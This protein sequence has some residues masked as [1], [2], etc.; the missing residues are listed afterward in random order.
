VPTVKGIFDVASVPTGS[1][2]IDVTVTGHQFWWQFEYPQQHITTANELHMP[3]GTPVYLSL[4]GADVIH[5]FW[6]PELSGT[7][8][9]VP[10]H[11]NH[12]MLQTNRPGIYLGQCKEFCG[13]SHANM[14]IRVFVQRPA[15]YQSWVAAQQQPAEAASLSGAAAAGQKLFLHGSSGGAFPGGPACSGC[16]SVSGTSAQGVIGP[17][18]THFGTRTRFASETYVNNTANLTNW[19]ENPPAL[20]PGVD[21][22]RLG[23]SSTQIRDL[24]AYLQSLK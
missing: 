2:V 5:S 22:P 19:L 1:N 13:L 9:V 18:L 14:R 6:V 15:A 21:M 4:K 8:D 24:V 20:K 16:H 23:L 17:N 7:Q 10:G 12:L 3:T 11:E